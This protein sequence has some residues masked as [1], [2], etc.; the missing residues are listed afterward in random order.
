MGIATDD[1]FGI[2]NILSTLGIESI[3]QGASTGT[4]WLR[5]DG[6]QIVSR[7]PVDAS[8]VGR[9]SAATETA[10][11]QVITPGT[12]RVFRMAYLASTSSW[13]GS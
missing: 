5:T 12:K 10:Y 6:E 11:E 2:K 13:G 7:S 9:I 3:S 1:S 4:K 8:E